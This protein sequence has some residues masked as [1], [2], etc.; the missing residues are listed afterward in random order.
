MSS[1]IKKTITAAIALVALAGLY[2]AGIY[3]GLY[4]NLERDGQI[5]TVARPADAVALGVAR[6]KQA[7][8]ALGAPQSKQV[9]FGD[10]HV[11]TTFSTDAFLFNLPFMQGEGAHPP[12]DACDFARYCSALDF[13]SINDH[14]ESLTPR[15][16][17]EIKQSIRQ[18]NDVAGNPDNPHPH[19]ALPSLRSFP[20]RRAGRR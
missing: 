4:G 6:Q 10:L 14:A 17:S 8:A 18:C 12:A 5:S 9:L 2:V 3:F 16:W 11:H 13:Y 1:N 15:K 19:S 20:A 7:M